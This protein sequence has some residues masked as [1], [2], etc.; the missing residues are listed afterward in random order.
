MAAGRKTPALKKPWLSA[1]MQRTDAAQTASA[2]KPELVKKA[3]AKPP[4]KRR[5]PRAL[6][7]QKHVLVPETD[8]SG[9]PL[10][11][12]KRDD[13]INRRI[14][15]IANPLMEHY[16]IWLLSPD[17][18]RHLSWCLLEECGLITFAPPKE[19]RRERVW[20]QGG[21]E[22]VQ[23]MDEIVAKGKLTVR[24]AAGVLIGRH[25][26]YKHLDAS[27]LLLIDTMKPNRH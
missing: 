21:T 3:S 7:K 26:E 5:I 6:R 17:R 22:L 20:K 16:G 2:E 10:V 24:A 15:E 12:Q 9:Q 11:G 1:V 14:E 4:T 23:R 8:L 19:G 18:W 13:Y 25:P 27:R